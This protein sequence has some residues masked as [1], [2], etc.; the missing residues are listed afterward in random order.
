VKEKDSR[1]SSLQALARWI[2]ETAKQSLPAAAV[3]QAKLLVLDTLGC[4][5]AGQHEE[6]SQSTLSLID[7]LGGHP[8]CTVIGRPQK[9]SPLNAVLANGCSIRALDLNDYVGGIVGGSP[10]I[11]G[12]PSD[13]IPSALAAGEMQGSCGAD[14]LAAIVIG[15]EIF[16]RLKSLLDPAGIWDEVT[17]SGVV[18]PAIAGRLLDLDQDRLAHALAL[19]A[20]RAATPNIVRRGHI[21]AA[22]SLA[23]AL[24]AQSGFQAALLAERGTTGPLGALDASRGLISL[25]SNGKAVEIL[26]APMPDVP[27]ILRSHVKTYPCLATGQSAVAAALKLHGMLGDAVHRLERIDVVMADYPIVK[28]QQQDPDRIH[29]MSREAADHSFNFL[30]AVSLLDGKFGLRQY[31][32][33]RWL[34]PEVMELMN[35][36]TMKSDESWAVRAPG[37]YPCR[38]QAWDRDGREWSA[39]VAFP[40]GFSHGRLEADAVIEKFHAVTG[41]HFVASR[42]EEIIEAALKLNRSA[43]ATELMNAVRTDS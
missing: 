30:I 27:Y 41:G 8:R 23:N 33:D 39:D 17:V 19:G 16:G 18:A 4:G 38:L 1:P 13:N 31:E 7:S 26:S 28:R 34:D 32:S 21:S 5:I 12:H 15:Y 14:I 6:V 20:V 43:S 11:G 40:P 29:P 42:R 36:L 2:S 22:K 25:F 35:R 24:V 9:T 37:S 10:Q 3:E